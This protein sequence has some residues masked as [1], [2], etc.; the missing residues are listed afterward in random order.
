[1]YLEVLAYLDPR[2]SELGVVSAL[3][4]SWLSFGGGDVR[5]THLISK[6]LLFLVTTEVSWYGNALFG[7]WNALFFFFF[8][9]PL[10]LNVMT[11]TWC[12]SKANK[13][14]RRLQSVNSWAAGHRDHEADPSCF[15]WPSPPSPLQDTVLWASPRSWCWRSRWEMKIFLVSKSLPLL[16]F[17]VAVGLTAPGLPRF[18]FPCAGTEWGQ[19]LGYF[20]SH[21]AVV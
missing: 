8:P 15:P 14:C 19:V 1:M 13:R 20:C 17:V 16:Q 7:I 11:Q 4:S 2:A 9:P 3:N 18:T 10:C 21:S 5:C 6:R 12:K